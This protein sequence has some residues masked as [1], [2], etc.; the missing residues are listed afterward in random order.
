LGLTALLFFA[1]P[2]TP[3][4]AI[5]GTIF[6]L[7]MAFV[8]VP[9]NTLFALLTPVDKRGRVNGVVNSVVNVSSL[10]VL[11]AAG[12]LAAA[13]GSSVGLGASG[14]S[15]SRSWGSACS[16]RATANSTGPTGC[17]S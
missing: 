11:A 13:V 4:V 7:G 16:C 1:H 2:G 5:G 12:L 14:C 10:L 8:N 9:I 17:S 6:G 3:V 15:L